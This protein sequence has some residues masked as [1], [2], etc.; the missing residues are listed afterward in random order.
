MLLLSALLPFYPD[1]IPLTGR[2]TLF[3]DDIKSDG[4]WKDYLADKKRK[5]AG[6][7]LPAGAFS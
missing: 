1:A 4:L 7:F 6:A 2:S 3:L 5:R